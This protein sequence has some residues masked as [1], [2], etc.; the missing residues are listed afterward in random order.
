MSFLKRT[1]QYKAFISYNQNA[2]RSHVEVIE[3]AVKE[4]SRKFSFVSRPVKLF[5]DKNHIVPGNSL[6]VAIKKALDN[7][8]YLILFA[9]EEAVKSNWV[10][11]ELEYWCERLGRAEHLI[12]LLS[13][14]TI[15][16]GH[17][18]NSNIG[19]VGQAVQR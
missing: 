14:G 17:A 11:L 1:K 3:E 13:N 4:Y 2:S 10:R 12:I 5:R 16:S 6:S 7:S 9:S 19:T 8:D 18:G 15:A